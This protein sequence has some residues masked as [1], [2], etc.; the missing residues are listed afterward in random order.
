M[1]NGGFRN[2][3]KGKRGEFKTDSGRFERMKRQRTGTAVR[4]TP[5]EQP[6]AASFLLLPSIGS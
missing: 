2:P 3:C 4:L 1:R 6:A 5:A